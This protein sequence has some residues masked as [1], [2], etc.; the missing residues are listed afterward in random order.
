VN[1]NRGSLVF[2]LSTIR[3]IDNWT[4]NP[5]YVLSYITGKVM[6]RLGGE[7][8][9]STSWRTVSPALY[10]VVSALGLFV[11]APLLKKQHKLAEIKGAEDANYQRAARSGI[12]LK[13]VIVILTIGITFLMVNKPQL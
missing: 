10:V 4:A 1:K 6:M 2:T 12:I 7:F 5:S 11:D 13:T 8:H 3:L 9:C